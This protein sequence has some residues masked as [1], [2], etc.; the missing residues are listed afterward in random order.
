MLMVDWSKRLVEFSMRTIQASEA[1]THLPELLD[2]IER[3][4]TLIITRHGRPIARIIPEIDRRAERT[5]QALANIAQLRNRT[6]RL[7][8]KDILSARNEGRA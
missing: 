8:V 5:E 7:S 2:D 3:G 1:K 4:E 6:G